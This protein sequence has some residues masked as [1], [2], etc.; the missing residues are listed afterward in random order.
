MNNLN[1]VDL[2]QEIADMQGKIEALLNED[3][4]AF[5]E[6]MNAYVEAWILGY[7]NLPADEQQAIRI[8]DAF[9]GLEQN[10]AFIMK[11]VKAGQEE[12]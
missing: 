9:V 7:K 5:F 8:M 1:L 2:P 11:T 4:A 6:A 10:L 12:E 3:S